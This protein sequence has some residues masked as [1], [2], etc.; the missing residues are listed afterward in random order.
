M[1]KHRVDPVILSIFSRK[2]NGE[3]QQFNGRDLDQ[4]LILCT[5]FHSK[6]DIR[7]NFEPI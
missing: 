2:V 7:E 6:N 5:L 1:I 4:I 3:Y